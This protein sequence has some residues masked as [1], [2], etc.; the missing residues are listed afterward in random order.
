[1]GNGLE[2]ALEDWSAVVDALERHR[3]EQVQLETAY[4]IAKFNL[5]EASAEGENDAHLN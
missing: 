5:D 1:M 2:D 3:R 4:E